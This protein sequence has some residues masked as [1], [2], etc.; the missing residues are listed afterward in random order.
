LYK[1]QNINIKEE[2]YE[3]YEDKGYIA[4]IE[5]FML[6]DGPGIRTV[7]FLKGC[8]L[9]C[10]WCS[11]PQT[12]EKELQIIWKKDKCIGCNRC[13][14]VCPQQAIVMSGEGKKVIY[15]K[16][17]KCG[18]CIDNCP[19]GALEYDGAIFSVEEAIKEVLKDEIFYRRSGGGITLSG[20][21][22]T[23][24]FQFSKSLL[25]QLKK[26]GIHTAVESCGFVKWERFKE[27]L[28]YVD[29]LLIDI[30]HMDSQKHRLFTGKSNVQILENIKLAKKNDLCEIL[31]RYPVIPAY[32]DSMDNI[33]SMI[34]FMKE[35]GLEKIDIF[36]FHKLGE[37]EYEELGREYPMKN[38][39][40]PSEE[41]I[42]EIKEYFR[43]KGIKVST[44]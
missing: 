34:N 2:Q 13:I 38:I 7:I 11:S 1:G 44:L 39:E 17:T 12:W 20:G 36:P 4:R 8:P 32:N 33:K 10:L 16:C 26:K 42:E 40:V 27:V 43:T 15:E 23:Y 19:I 5:R 25:M 37:H 6:H 14:E 24:Q 22:P 35:T 28:K 9:R 29:T 31:I 18:K 3:D 21:E 30:K 41:R